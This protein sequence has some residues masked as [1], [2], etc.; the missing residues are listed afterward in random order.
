MPSSFA[1]RTFGTLANA[2]QRAHVNSNEFPCVSQM[3]THVSTTNWSFS[4]IFAK[5]KL[6]N[7]KSGLNA[8]LVLIP[9]RPNYRI[10]HFFRAFFAYIFKNSMATP[11][12]FSD[13]AFGMKKSSKFCK[14]KKVYVFRAQI[15]VI[16]TFSRLYQ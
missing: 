15:T 3:K 13:F 1:L 16:L 2:H 8:N 4:V 7:I 10:H 9:A 11:N 5:K 6:Y 14:K 12:F